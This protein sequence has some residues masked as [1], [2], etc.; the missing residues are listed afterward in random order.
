MKTQ[1]CS[2]MYTCLTGLVSARNSEGLERKRHLETQCLTDFKA[3]GFNGHESKSGGLHEEHA[4]AT[5]N[6]GNYLSI[7]FKREEKQEN[8]CR[9]GRSQDFR[10]HT[11]F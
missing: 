11:D 4:V 8:L 5:W 6:R 9:D 3:R 10:M 7:R 2:E 1:N